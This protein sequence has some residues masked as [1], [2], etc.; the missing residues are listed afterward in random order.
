MRDDHSLNTRLI[1]LIMN[2]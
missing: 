1:L 2:M